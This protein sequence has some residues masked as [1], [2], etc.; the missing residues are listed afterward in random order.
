MPGRT[1]LF[2]QMPQNA[3]GESHID[4]GGSNPYPRRHGQVHHEP[5]RAAT[6]A[7]GVPGAP[8]VLPYAEAR[9]VV[10]QMCTTYCP[11]HEQ[12]MLTSLAPA[13]AVSLYSIALL[14]LRGGRLT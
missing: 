3:L 11:I 13:S 4:G 12:P 5:A 9:T 10:S 7:P 6:L 8:G 2:P 14:R 1:G